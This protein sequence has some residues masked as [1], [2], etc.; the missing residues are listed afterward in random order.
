MICIVLGIIIYV[1]GTA[2]GLL[3]L[4]YGKIGDSFKEGGAE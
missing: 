4:A 2:V 3:F 1:V